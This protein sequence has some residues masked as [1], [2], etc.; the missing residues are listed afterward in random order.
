[1]LLIFTSSCKEGKF[2]RGY[3]G[4]YRSGLELKPKIFAL[5]LNK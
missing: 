2:L 3:D 1:M 4:L 5:I